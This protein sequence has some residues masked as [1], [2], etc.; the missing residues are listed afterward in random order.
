MNLYHLPNKYKSKIETHVSHNRLTQAHTQTKKRHINKLFFLG[1]IK[2]KAK[3]YNFLV[4]NHYLFCVCEMPPRDHLRQTH[5]YGL[6]HHSVVIGWVSSF[7]LPL[8]IDCFNVLMNNT[9][10]L[11]LFFGEKRGLLL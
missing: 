9:I 10:N 5:K 8:L 4:V 6:T 3:M 1:E 7:L 11:L 2:I